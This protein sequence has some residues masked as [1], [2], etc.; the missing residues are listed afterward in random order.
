MMMYSDPRL[1]LEQSLSLGHFSLILQ[2]FSISIFRTRESDLL[3]NKFFSNS[4]QSIISRNICKTC[5]PMIKIVN[6]F[7]LQ[8]FI[9]LALKIKQNIPLKF[10]FNIADVQSQLNLLICILI[11][12]F[13]HP[14][15]SSPPRIHQLN[16]IIVK[17]RDKIYPKTPIFLQQY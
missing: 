9:I 10:I 14:W 1:S 17:R 5:V 4:K 8:K 15:E 11:Y 7:Y 2:A 3:I 16:Y 13:I 12:T 6:Y